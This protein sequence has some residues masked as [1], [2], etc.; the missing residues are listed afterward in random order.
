MAIKTSIKP[1]LKAVKKS[2]EIVKIKPILK[3]DYIYAVGKRKSAVARIRLH[4]AKKSDGK[5]IINNKDLNKYFPTFEL[6]QIVTCPLALLGLNNKF[7]ITIK[8]LGGGIRGQA[9]SIRHGIAR[10]LLKLD[11]N[12]R[13]SLRAAGL[14]TRDSRKKERKKPGLKRAR[15]APQ[16]AKR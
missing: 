1:K 3:H 8:V 15:R 10:A 6:Q 11:I 9:D 5:I 4:D 16:W 7:N 2:E 12:N 13:K 14:L